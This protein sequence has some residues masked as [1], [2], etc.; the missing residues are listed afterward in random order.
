ML[1]SNFEQLKFIFI[2]Q[3]SSLS[4]TIIVHFPNGNSRGQ[5]TGREGGEMAGIVLET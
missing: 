5:G 4:I 1:L 2:C 3:I